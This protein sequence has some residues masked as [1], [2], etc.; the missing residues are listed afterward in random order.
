M[1]SLEQILI[2]AEKVLLSSPKE[3]LVGLSTTANSNNPPLY[4]SANRE[5][6]KTISINFIFRET[7]QLKQIIEFFDGKVSFFLI[8]CEVKNEVDNLEELSIPLIRKS[9]YHLV[10]PN[11]YAV[12]AMDEFLANSYRSLKGITVGIVGAGN[13]GGKIAL[14]AAE[15]GAQVKLYGRDLKK[16]ASIVEGLNLLFKAR[17][18]IV[19]SLNLEEVAMNTHCLIGATSGTPAIDVASVE[20]LAKNAMIIDAGNNTFFPNAIRFATENGIK[21]YCLSAMAGY[22][23]SIANWIATRNSISQ[24]GTRKVSDDVTLVSLG[25]IGK[26]GDVLVNNVSNPTKVFG[27]C[28]GNGDLLSPEEATPFIERYNSL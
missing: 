10:K 2:K 21:A 5:T 24:I 12:A 14:L 19:A 28:D 8:D 13:L 22:E 9:R 20:L 7:S 18:K 1:T 3:K 6:E 23:A 11:D 15:R 27:V 16:T 25:L 4:L 26:H 17:T